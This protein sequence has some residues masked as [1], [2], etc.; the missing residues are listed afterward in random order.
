MLEIFSRRPMVILLSVLWGIGL[1]TL[2]SSVANNR[3]CIIV[4]G[5]LPADVEKMVFQY[6]DLEDKCYTYKS[7]IT[8]C[9]NEIYKVVK[10]APK[11]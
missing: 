9:E 4:R 3:N 1:A 11:K 2:F 8:P 7:Y 6:P 10:V 5:E